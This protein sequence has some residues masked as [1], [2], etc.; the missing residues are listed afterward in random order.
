MKL[1]ALSTILT[2]AVFSLA[3]MIA[4]TAPSAANAQAAGDYRCTTLQ[5]QA[6]AAAASATDA[7]QLQRA[8]RFIAVGR[9]LCDARAEGQAA[10]QFRSALRILGVD[11]VRNPTAGQMATTATTTTGGN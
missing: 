6:R 11:E 10:R 2:V 1:S 9:Q 5:D 8:Q 7:G 3:P 4:F